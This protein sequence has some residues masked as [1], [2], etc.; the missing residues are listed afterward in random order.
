MY[1]R[2]D[3]I[4]AISEGVA[5]SLQGW[6][7][8]DLVEK[9]MSIIPNGARD[10][11]SVRFS[12]T[13]RR[14]DIRKLRV[15]F[16]GTDFYKKGLDVALHAIAESREVIA[17]FRVLGLCGENEDVSRMS[18]RLGIQDIV[19]VVGWSDKV[20]EE[21]AAADVLL[22]SSRWEGFGLA[23][24]EAMSAGVPVV[25]SDVAGLREISAESACTGIRLVTAEDVG[26]FANALREL[27]DPAVRRQMGDSARVRAK[28]FTIDKMLARYAAL[29]WNIAGARP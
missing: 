4:V 24:V 6:V 9:R 19:D 14:G 12:G 22:M 23:A 3:S 7:R 28:D 27:S 16:M 21:M 11:G 18:D 29:Y 5:S 26:G 15:L 17:S 25:A 2:Y 13:E 1:E 8:S 20:E 10:F